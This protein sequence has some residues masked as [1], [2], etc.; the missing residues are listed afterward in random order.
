MG[1]AD[2]LIKLEIPYDSEKAEKFAEKTMKLISESSRKASQELAK[3]RGVFPNMPQSIYRKEKKPLRN[4]TLTTIAPTGTIAIIANCSESIEPIFSPI[5]TRNSTYGLMYEINP[6]FRELVKKL[7]LSQQSI[8][9][10]AREG[11]LQNIPEIPEKIKRVFKTAHDISPEWHLRIQ[12]AF[13]KYTDNAVSKT[14]NLPERATPTDVENVF[15]LAYKLK[16]KGLTVYRYNSRKE[17]VLEFCKK[18]DVKL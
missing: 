3:A 6:L 5:F 9:K 4:S 15:L 7:R 17:Q 2:A 18:C 10:I 13:Q 12:A 14:I 8:E 16:L 11:S 1:F